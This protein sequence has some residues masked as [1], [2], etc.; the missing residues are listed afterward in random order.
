M[1]RDTGAIQEPT[2]DG[3]RVVMLS[4]SSAHQGQNFPSA[5]G[6]GGGGREL[7]QD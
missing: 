7:I 3:H 5:A 4:T 1:R 2:G 6:G